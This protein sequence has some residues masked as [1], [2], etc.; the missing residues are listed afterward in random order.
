MGVSGAGKTTVAQRLAGALGLP[1]IEADDFHSPGA[2]AKT[3]RGEAMT[4]EDRDP[5]LDRLNAELRARPGGAV[6]ACSA[7]AERHRERLLR[8]VEDVRLVFLTA[9]PALIRARLAARR[10]EAG[11]ELLDSQLA[12]LEPPPD[13]VT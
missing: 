2:R 8:D 9:D 13:A 10:G 6:L 5:W 7:L 3:R 12:T 1:Y 4:D 11:P